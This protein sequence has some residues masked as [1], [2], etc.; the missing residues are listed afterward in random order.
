M[1]FEPMFRPADTDPI[2]TDEATVAALAA[3]L[4]ALVDRFAKESEQGTVSPETGRALAALLSSA[5]R[6]ERRALRSRQ[7]AFAD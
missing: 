4:E 7:P 6:L 5:H 2:G 1:S 3:D